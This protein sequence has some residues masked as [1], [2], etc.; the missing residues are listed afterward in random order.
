MEENITKKMAKHYRKFKLE[1]LSDIGLYTSATQF[2][3]LDLRKLLLHYTTLFEKYNIYKG[4]N[5]YNNYFIKNTCYIN[6]SIQSL[7]LYSILV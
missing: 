4:D 7:Y 6:Y 2:F 3:H 1:T 5:N